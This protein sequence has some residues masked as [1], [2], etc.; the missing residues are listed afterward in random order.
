M[1]SLP[2]SGCWP[3]PYP[4]AVGDLILELS[5]KAERDR[6]VLGN[7]EGKFH[8][9]FAKQERIVAVDGLGRDG[10]DSADRFHEYGFNIGVAD[11]VFRPEILRFQDDLFLEQSREIR[12]LTDYN[13][14]LANLDRAKGITLE[15]LNIGIGER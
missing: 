7:R 15:R 3:Q 1:T 13:I 12:A 8:S 10:P 14:S 6:A 5:I 9:A 11:L 2:T 4:E